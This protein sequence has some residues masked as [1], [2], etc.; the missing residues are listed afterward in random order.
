MKKCIFTRLPQDIHVLLF[1]LCANKVSQIIIPADTND[2]D[3]DPGLLLQLNEM[4]PSLNKFVV[5]STRGAVSDAPFSKINEFNKEIATVIVPEHYVPNCNY[6]ITC[7]KLYKK[8]ELLMQS[9]ERIT[10][11]LNKHP[12][13][14]LQY[15][16][17]G[18]NLEFFKQYILLFRANNLCKTTYCPYDTNTNRTKIKQY[19]SLLGLNVETVTENVTLRNGWAM[20]TNCCASTP[21]C[22]EYAYIKAKLFKGA[23][24][25]ANLKIT[26]NVKR[27]SVINTTICPHNSV[28]IKVSKTPKI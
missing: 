6:F 18:Q 3:D 20:C 8:R 28:I 12:F 10:I 25:D 19:C 15:C 13:R 24:R 5:H 27:K 22:C 17:Y 1:K 9:F 23:A 14:F 11:P 2:D 4:A 7:R 26:K 16:H 21:E